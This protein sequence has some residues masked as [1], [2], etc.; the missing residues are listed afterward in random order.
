MKN[1][2]NA[3]Y[4]IVEPIIMTA[5]R[6][7]VIANRLFFHSLDIS[8][9]NVKILHVLCHQ[10]DIT[11]KEIL[12]LVGGTKSNI[13]QRLDALEKKGL[14]IMKR[15]ADHDKRKV[16]VQLTDQGKKKLQAIKVH[17][18]KI[19]KELES[20]FTQKEIQQHFVFFKKLNR[21]LDSKDKN[22]S[23]YKKIFCN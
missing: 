11:P 6:M 19:K 21:L 20:H 13:S 1:E 18:G 22:F 12:E 9:A 16:Q 2:V 8:V 5:A 17:I 15:Q 10:P 3:Y 4:S 7:E 23:V 14:I